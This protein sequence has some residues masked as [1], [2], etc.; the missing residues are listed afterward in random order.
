MSDPGFA[1]EVRRARWFAA[2][3][4]PFAPQH[5]LR[6]SIAEDLR[7][8]A[9]IPVA[10]Q[11]ASL[12][13]TRAET[14]A[15]GAKWLMRGTERRRYLQRLRQEKQLE[16]ALAWRAAQS[17]FDERARDVVA[18]LKGEGIFRPEA[19]A[20]VL[21]PSQPQAD[22]R[23]ALLRLAYGLEWAGPDAPGFA[24]L[25]RIRALLS[26]F[27]DAERARTILGSG[28]QARDEDV[29]A[30]SDWIGTPSTEPPVQALFITGLPGIGKSALL[31]AAAARAQTGE[32]AIL[33]IRLDFDRPSL[34]VL[35][36]RGLALEATR[37]LA[38]QLPDRAG[39][40]REVRLR[41][42]GDPVRREV[43][44]EWIP[45][46]LLD[47]MR[48][49]V[50]GAA[51]C[52]VLV[53]LDTCEVLR[54]R[55]EQH[56][57]GLFRWLDALLAGGV[58]PMSVIAAGRGDAL[59]PVP[60]RVGQARSINALSPESADLVL[61]SLNV[62]ATVRPALHREA[63]GHPLLL[64]LHAVA[65]RSEDG[66]GV[67][68]RASR[69]RGKG[70]E[71][72]YLYRFV[73][74]RLHAPELRLAAER[75][76]LIVRRVDIDTIRELW[77]A[78]TKTKLTEASAKRLFE[79]LEAQAWLLERDPV[80]PGWLRQRTDM[81][82]ELL[83]LLYA[84]A[85]SACA[86]VDRAAAGY[87]SRRKEPW[88]EVDAAYHRLQLMRSGEPAPRLDRDVVTRFGENLLAELPQA[89]RNHLLQSRGERSGMARGAA[90][91]SLQGK[92]AEEVD[93]GAV[94][95]LAF[96]MER[97]DWEEAAHVHATLFRHRTIPP[98]SSADHAVRTFLWRTGRWW[99]AR[100]RIGS[101]M[102]RI[103]AA[104]GKLREL[105]A[106]AWLEMRAEFAF[107]DTADRLGRD[108]SF[109]KAALNAINRSGKQDYADG[110]LGFALLATESWTGRRGMRTDPIQAVLELWSPSRS[111]ISLNSAI[112]SAGGLM[113]ERAPELRDQAPKAPG[114]LRTEAEGDQA[115]SARMLAVLTPYRAAATLRLR[116][117]GDDGSS[118]QAR[119]AIKLLREIPAW[120]N[121]GL[122]ATVRLGRGV[123]D[124]VDALADVGLFA[125]WAGAAAWRN[126]DENRALLA[127]GAEAWRS[128]IAGRWAYPVRPRYWPGKDES[129]LDVST[130]V[131]V[132]ELLDR[133]DRAD[134]SDALLKAWLGLDDK[135]Y[136]PTR[137]TLLRSARDATAKTARDGVASEWITAVARGL[138]D[139]RIPAALVP[140]LAILAAAP[141]LDD[142]RI[143][144]ATVR[145][146]NLA[147][148]V[149]RMTRANQESI[150]RLETIRLRSPGMLVAAQKA[151]EEGRV[152]PERFGLRRQ[153]AL[154][155]TAAPHRLEALGVPATALEA[156]VRLT[157]RPPLLVKNGAV[158]MQPLDDFPSG[159]DAAIKA[160]E[161]FIPS[162]GR[163]EFLNFSM[164]WGGTG[165]VVER[166][167]DGFL[168]LTN[169]HVAVLVAKRGADGPIFM[170]SP[171]SGARY[172]A[173]IDF[174]EELNVPPDVA[175]VVPVTGI[176]YLA[177]DM[178]ADMALLKVRQPQP[179][180]FAMPDPVP[181]ADREAKDDEL[182][183]LVGYPAYDS[184]NDHTAMERYFQGLY[185]VK[186]FAPGRVIKQT[187]NTVLSHDCT[188]LGG[189]SGSVLLSLEQNKA[190]GIHFAG[191][192]GVE[193]SAV[194]VETIKA[195]LKG[196]LVT[197]G[198]LPSPEDVERADIVHKPEQLKDR[199]GFDQEFLGDGALTVPWP[200][201]PATVEAKLARPSDA[202]A[203]WP[204]ELRYTHFGVKFSTQ[205]RLPVLT[206][207]NIDGEHSQRVKRNSGSGDQWAFDGRIDLELQHGQKAYKDRE[208]DRGHMV[209]REDPIWGERAVAEQANLDTFHYT[210]AAPQHS[211][212]NQGKQ[213]WQGLENYILDNARTK[214]FKACV[215]TGPVFSEEDPVF[216][217][218]D[219]RVPMEFWKVVAMLDRDNGKLHATA[220]LLSQGQLIRKLMEERNRRETLEGFTLGEYRTF[221]VAIKDLEAA[222]GYD[223]GPLREADPLARAK[224][225]QEA[226][227]AGIPVVV[228]LDN[229]ADLRL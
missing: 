33:H 146:T 85:P 114:D 67:P 205:H 170:R 68:R 164:P 101:Y 111:G 34:D 187:A 48:D 206:A 167:T 123:S 131:R 200:K 103:D 1:D 94:E 110:S 196:T 99:E 58:G 35:N 116:T 128:T 44:S 37:Q 182:V 19:V 173:Q 222:T 96:C 140:P 84:R 54:N 13:D 209:R 20:G 161:P 60:E 104:L 86:K 199:D 214:G 129:E 139:Q 204:H 23:Q 211:R 134:Q 17:S 130:L 16:E 215:F 191:V 74:S 169:R 39:M 157:G 133:A 77:G 192:Y 95:E 52:T 32:R 100:E 150:G 31:E 79:L 217:E 89:A 229:A 176:E 55:G 179:A 163:V 117:T 218:D 45:F 208:I 56:P 80:A 49:A 6:A 153:S 194:G 91:S 198:Q 210:N 145:T 102:E 223:F 59:Q 177:E 132:H 224:G 221:Q 25:E 50:Q 15:D 106:L 109:L 149:S 71:I 112:S 12:C 156:I 11:L 62:P 226:L 219:V 183:A 69:R 135:S 70:A 66:D 168:V 181:L 227:D 143:R 98:L 36:P 82:A 76:A 144:P 14:D 113:V 73:L 30:L 124:P 186:R 201:V 171:G 180:N 160:A 207:V 21:A 22:G 195:L 28:V 148:G 7:A 126:A 4:G 72:A 29:Q 127:N 24:Q 152:D 5:A 97:G 165:W 81:R 46:E 136:G 90:D 78:L 147:M 27:D 155:A 118:A 151:L 93:P 203:K 142:R 2:L 42:A 172:G 158:V 159:S 43:S 138:R 184:R 119:A 125:E 105:D 213:L 122:T 189:N 220:Y 64:K 18:A 216:E 57:G 137:D 166:K 9:T 10:A 188:S 108:G 65:S 174:S 185:D 193:N 141:A 92:E 83:P 8:K 202:T 87:F 212:L 47:A 63:K 53:V 190:V 175:R 154:E 38:A 3:S 120:W 197:V 26:Q 115:F 61:K 88:L 41:Q 107:R 40:L 51:P 162:I 178:A 75:Y 228:P 121:G 225:A